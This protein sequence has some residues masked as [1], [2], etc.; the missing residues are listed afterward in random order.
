MRRI[1]IIQLAVAATV[2]AVASCAY[3]PAPVP[4]VGSPHGIRRLVGTWSGEYATI[5]PDRN[6]TI[7]FR[8][9]AVSDTAYGDVAMA[10]NSNADMS[11]SGMRP[12]GPQRTWV[13]FA[14]TFVQVEGSFVVGQ[15]DPYIDPDLENRVATRFRGTFTSDSTLGGTFVTVDV[16]GQVVRR[17]TWN[18]VRTA[19]RVSGSPVHALRHP[20]DSRPFPVVASWMQG[21]APDHAGGLSPSSLRLLCAS[22]P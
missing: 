7:M 2:A 21:S 15:L 5:P 4:L 6:G 20:P 12:A 13:L 10:P 19:V 17:G 22:T 8:L 3:H 14:I 18:V 11:Q 9:R 16:W 1:T